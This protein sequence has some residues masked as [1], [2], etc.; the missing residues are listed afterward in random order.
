[1]SDKLV[2]MLLTISP[3]QPHLCGTPFFQ[4]AA[5]AAMD[6]EVEIYFA[7]SATRLLVR[8]IADGIHPSDNK[9]KSVY[10][11]MQD[12]AQL[13][14]KFF[15]CGGALEAYAITSELLIPECTGIAGAAAYIC[16][17]MDDDWKS[18]AY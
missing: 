8:G 4:A 17:V 6:A 1:M 7:S 9:A 10:G 15:A 13:G 2:M 5:A 3:D 18:I 12:A 11:F 16:R 14:V